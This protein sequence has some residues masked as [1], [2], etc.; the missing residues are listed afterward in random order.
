M[1]KGND[2]MDTGQQLVVKTKYIKHVTLDTRQKKEI[3][4]LHIQKTINMTYTGQRH[5]DSDT[6]Q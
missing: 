2:N 4:G 5:R 1:N 3:S 6:G